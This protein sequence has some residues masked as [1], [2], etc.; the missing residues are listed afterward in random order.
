MTRIRKTCLLLVTFL[1]IGALSW[2]VTAASACGEASDCTVGSRTYRI[3][4]P[5]N[6][7]TP[8]GIGAIIFIH[9]YRGTAAGIMKN[10]GL[11]ALASELNVAFVAAQAAGPEWNIP[12]IPS[13]DSLTG[14]DEL[15]YFDDL[16]ADLTSRFHVDPSRIM[17][18]GFSSGAM[19]VWH[20]ACHRG[21]SFAGFA[22]MSG[23]FWKPIPENCPT[24]AVNLIHFHGRQDPVVPLHGQQ[25]KDAHQGDVFEALDL[26]IRTG[27]YQP[28]GKEQPPG[29][30]CSRWAD[31]AHHLLEFCLFDGKHSFRIENLEYAAGLFLAD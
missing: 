23:T 1:A 14:V 17:V 20:L 22:P 29:L 21:T 27:G 25:I 13:S 8:D 6:A 12:H 30:D 9:G 2:Q 10:K 28:I 11:T 24:G 4:L 7:A 3:V 15:A 31:Q 16:V 18:A 26:M 5:E 19:V